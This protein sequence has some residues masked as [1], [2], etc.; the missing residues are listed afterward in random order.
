MQTEPAEI[1]IDNLIAKLRHYYPTNFKLIN[2]AFTLARDAHANQFRASG[3]PYIT[4]P[5][6][7]ADILVDLG[8]SVRLFFTI[9]SRIPTLPTKCSGRNSATR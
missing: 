3:R 8:R 7:V 1:T 6:V 4:H 2:E 5:V 9:R